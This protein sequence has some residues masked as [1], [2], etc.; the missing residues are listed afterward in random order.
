M[1][2]AALTRCESCTTCDR[3]ARPESAP[4][5]ASLFDNIDRDKSG[6]ISRAEW[7]YAFDSL[8]QV[9]GDTIS[10]RDWVQQVGHG[11][12]FDALD[13]DRSGTI[14]RHEWLL[15]FDIF[16]RNGDGCITSSEL[17]SAHLKV[18][19]EASTRRPQG[20]SRP[21]SRSSAR[22][23]EASR[24][25]SNRHILESC[26]QPCP[27]AH[28]LHI[29]VAEGWGRSRQNP[30]ARK[31]LHVAEQGCLDSGVRLLEISELARSNWRFCCDQQGD[32][33]LHL[34]IRHERPH[35]VG[36]LL[37]HRAQLD[38]RNLNG[39]APLHTACATGVAEVVELLCN[40]S[41]DPRL[42]D[43]QGNEAPGLW[44]VRRHAEQFK[45]HPEVA[46]ASRPPGQ[47]P[48]QHRERRFVCIEACLKAMRLWDPKEPAAASL[49]NSK[50]VTGLHIAAEAADVDVCQLLLAFHAVV[51]SED[52]QGTTPLMY[53]VRAGAALAVVRFLLSAAASPGVKDL[54]GGSPLHYAVAAGDDSLSTVDLLLASRADADA[55]DE[56]GAS[57]LALAGLRGAPAVV[58]RLLA[59]GARPE[60]CRELLPSMPT[61]ST[62]PDG[63]SCREIF[64][65]VISGPTPP[66]LSPFAA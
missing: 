43:L 39:E 23:S 35:F 41:A 32:S 46:Q 55:V 36:L 33:A 49:V 22:T 37:K 53:A 50:G 9:E 38:M 17:E 5:F 16:D 19:R 63:K 58:R 10:R 66:A 2:S 20:S 4:V 1:G 27:S 28:V 51:D 52:L 29:M 64:E 44:A 30:E 47:Q 62:A 21:I 13:A 3:P 54:C 18:R 14:T 12:M 61:G 8:K 15:A 26:V 31:L 48:K 45:Q 65:A 6:T 42:G 60:A 40:V 57:A 59:A 11:F 7:I 25:Q 34:A 56:R 24:A